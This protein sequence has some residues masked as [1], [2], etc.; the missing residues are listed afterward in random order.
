MLPPQ[1]VLVSM[2]PDLLAEL[3]GNPGAA[4]NQSRRRS[5]PPASPNQFNQSLLPGA[6]PMLASLVRGAQNIELL[7]AVDLKITG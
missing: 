2:P 6:D 1:E 3:G 4:A 5:P 7:L